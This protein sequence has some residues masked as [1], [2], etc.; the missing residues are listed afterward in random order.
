MSA[1]IASALSSSA[2]AGFGGGGGV[3]VV[4]VVLLVAVHKEPE[5]VLAVRRR[6]V[7]RYGLVA[8]ILYGDMTPFQ[9]SYQPYCARHA[10]S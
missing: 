10:V 1:A 9:A 6:R 4:V 8:Q 5:D 7:E 2:W 3:E